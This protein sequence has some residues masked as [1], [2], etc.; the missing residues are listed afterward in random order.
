MKSSTGKSP[1]VVF[2]LK[3]KVNLKNSNIN[4][5]KNEL[6]FSSSHALLHKQREFAPAPLHEKE[7]KGREEEEEMYRQYVYVWDYE[8]VCAYAMR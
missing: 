5:E 7:E 2:F 6:W 8:C 4:K 1:C 3:K